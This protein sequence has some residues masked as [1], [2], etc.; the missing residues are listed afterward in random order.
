MLLSPAI[1]LTISL[2]ESTN[3]FGNSLSCL[4]ES[5]R[6]LF[7]M[8]QLDVTLF[9]TLYVSLGGIRCRV[10]ASSPPLFITITDIKTVW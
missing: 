3:S 1:G 4:E 2:W 8:I 10:G 6:P 7:P 9:L 5:I